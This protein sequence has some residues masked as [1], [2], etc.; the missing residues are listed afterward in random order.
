MSDRNLVISSQKY[1]EIS[2]HSITQTEIEILRVWKNNNRSAFFYKGIITSSDQINWFQNFLRRPDDHM[3]IVQVNSHNIGCMGIRFVENCW[4]VYN[5]ILGESAYAKTGYMGHGF[6]M[7][8]S[9]AIGEKDMKVM[10]KVLKDNPALGWYLKNSFRI[11]SDEGDFVSI[12]LDSTLFSMCT[13]TIG[14]E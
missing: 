5:V 13:L 9:F 7:M 6:Q 8:C 10:A 14:A 3:F 2:L 12:I 1:P 11:L 4:D